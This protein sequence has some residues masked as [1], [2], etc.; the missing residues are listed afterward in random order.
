MQKIK[1][2]VEKGLPIVLDMVKSVAFVK[3]IGKS[4]S[5]MYNKLNHNVICDIEGRFSGSDAELLNKGMKILGTKLLGV[6]ITYSEDRQDVI[7]QVKSVAKVI[8]MPYIYIDRMGKCKDWYKNRTC[9]RKGT[10]TPRFSEDDILFFNMSIVEIAN[11]LLSMEL[12]AYNA[13]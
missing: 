10:V 13:F 2:D 3:E 4:D 9:N 1:I 6:R 5:W 7:D 12:A 8:R 11:K